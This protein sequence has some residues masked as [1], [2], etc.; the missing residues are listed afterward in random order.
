[1]PLDTDEHGSLHL[2]HRAA[3]RPK[4]VR[5]RIKQ[6]DE[7]V[8]EVGRNI[9][10]QTPESIEDHI[11]DARDSL[12]DEELF[13]ELNVEAQSL[14]AYGV[15]WRASTIH[16]PMESWQEETEVLVDL[17]PLT[18]PT[19]GSVPVTDAARYIATSLKVFM[20]HTYSQRLARR[21]KPPPPLTERRLAR[22]PSNILRVL[23]SHDIHNA[24]VQRMRR[25][26]S[27]LKEVYL[28]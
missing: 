24:A 8:G 18:E 19:N 10:E 4:M 25:Y 7:I 28:G 6:G 9:N 27:N 1:M 17:V 23:L 26:L 14:T 15:K 20:L 21:S 13:H 5:V 16:I 11:R 3:Y 12:F 2:T 22:P